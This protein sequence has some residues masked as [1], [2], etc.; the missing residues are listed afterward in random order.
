MFHVKR[1]QLDDV[2]AW[3][4][5]AAPVGLLDR[6]EAFERWLVTEGVVSGG[7]GPNESDI[8][9]RHILDSVMFARG[10]DTPPASIIDLGSGVGLPGVPLALLF[11]KSAVVLVD[12]SGRRLASARRVARVLRLESVSTIQAEFSGYFGEADGVV[13]RAALPSDDAGDEIRRHLAP[14]GVGVLGI[15]RTAPETKDGIIERFPGSE[16]LDPGRWLHIMRG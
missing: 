9:V 14:G 5:H 2:L 12:R 3:V 13:M 8:W 1:R 7:V 15:G 16:V 4:G 6:L 11:P 10:F